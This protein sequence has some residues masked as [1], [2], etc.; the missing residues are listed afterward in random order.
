VSVL[1]RSRLPTSRSPGR[2][3]RAFGAVPA[4]GWMCAAIAAANVAVWAVLIPPFQIPDEI[5]HVS[6]VQ[7]LVERRDLPTPLADSG[8]V[9]AEDLAAAAGGIP[10]TVEGRP[11]WDPVADRRFHR[12]LDSNPSR[13]PTGVGAASVN[14]PPLYYALE[15]VPYSIGRGAEISTRLLLMRLL[16]ALIAGATVLFTF[17]FV[18]EVLPSTPW[19]WTVGALAVAFQPVFGFISAGISN[20]TMVYALGAA[21]L[22]MVARCFRRGLTPA[23]GAALGGVVLAGLLTKSSF[24]GLLPGIALGLLLMI[25]R[26]GPGGRVVAA[27]GAATAALVAALPFA[28]W[29]LANEQL[30]D[31]VATT[32][33]GFTSS[34]VNQAVTLGAQ[35]SYAWQFYLPRLPFMTDWFRDYPLWDTYFEGFVGRFGW[36]QYDF[37]TWVYWLGLGVFAALV[38]LAAA[39]VAGARPWRSGRWVE[40]ATYGAILAGMAAFVTVAGYR[41][42]VLHYQPFE[43][44]RYLFP[45]LALWGLLV[46]VGARAGGR[47][48]GP[49]LGSFIVVLLMGHSLFAMLLTV[50]RYYA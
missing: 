19:A 20:E 29:M 7:Y 17:L 39:A 22:Y 45:A 49:A 5:D 31:R 12:V 9:Y 35:L 38:A 43:Q 37:P 48:W 25:W 11:E 14:N 13:R 6:Y 40:L 30:F 42:L 46:A 3:R 44:T 28:A 4:A 34:T 8:G 16:S 24:L 18:R 36:F 41:Y 23:T 21:A 47:R 27:K 50:A 32:T 15:A 2:V 26:S 1:T 33:G 10:F